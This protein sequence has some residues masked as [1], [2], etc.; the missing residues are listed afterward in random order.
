MP[1]ISVNIS[2]AGKASHTPVIP[3]V[4]DRRK[5]KSTI[6]AIPLENAIME[7]SRPFPVALRKPAFTMLKAAKR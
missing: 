5:A 2:D 7:D 3:M 6:A 1:I 4:S